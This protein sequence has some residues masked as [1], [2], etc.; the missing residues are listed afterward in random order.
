[1]CFHLSRSIKLQSCRKVLHIFPTNKEVR[2]HN[3]EMFKVVCDILVMSKEQDVFYFTNST[4][5][6]LTLRDEP[7][8]KCSSADLQDFLELGTDARVM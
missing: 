4:S 6:K 3:E 1:M 8:S 2:K 7:Y 5:G